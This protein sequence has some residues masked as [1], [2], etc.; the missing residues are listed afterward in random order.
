[1]LLL[2][3]AESKH[4]LLRAVLHVVRWLR[5]TS[6]PRGWRWCPHR[7][8]GKERNLRSSILVATLQS[9]AINC[10]LAHTCFG[11]FLIPVPPSSLSGC[12]MHLTVEMRIYTLILDIVIQ[13]YIIHVSC[14]IVWCTVHGFSCA[15]RSR[16]ALWDFLRLVLSIPTLV[17]TS[18]GLI[19]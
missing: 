12:T 15:C 13:C 16:M 18:A 14:C 11:S 1:M 10:L 4:S 3:P 9:S 2:Q 7:R 6:T 19:C 8:G 17:G 5:S